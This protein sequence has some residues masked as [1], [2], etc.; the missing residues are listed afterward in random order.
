[1]SAEP[2]VSIGT[3]GLTDVLLSSRYRL[4]DAAGSGPAGHVYAA[5]DVL[6][7]RAV[8]VKVLDAV[9]EEVGVGRAVRAA[10]AAARA[11]GARLVEVLDVEYGRPT[12]VVLGLV[13]AR[14]LPVAAP[15]GLGV[16]PA[17]TVAED[18]LSALAAL[19]AAGAVHRDV[20]AENVLLGE[21]GRAWLT[22]AGL[23]EAAR[24]VG[25]GLRVGADPLRRR[26]PAP[27]PEQDLGVPATARSDVAAAGALLG[28][29]LAGRGGPEVERVLRRATSPDPDARHRDAT[30]LLTA[31][32]AA[33]AAPRPR[34]ITRP[35]ALPAPPA[36]AAPPGPPAPPVTG[37]P[38]TPS[39]LVRAS[40]GPVAPAHAAATT[41]A[42]AVDEV[43][44]GRAE[45]EGY[46]VTV[47]VE[48]HVPRL[49]GRLTLAA[50]AITAAWLLVGAPIANLGAEEPPP[51]VPAVSGGLLPTPAGPA[52][53]GPDGLVAPAALPPQEL[54]AVLAVATT[55]QEDLGPRTEDLLS[56][57]Q[58][59]DRL[60]GITREAEAAELY[61][62]AAVD[63]VSASNSAQVS[64]EVADLLRP[65]VTL[66]GLAALVDLDPAAAGAL[67]RTF[68]ARVRVLATLEGEPRREEAFALWL[69]SQQGVADATLTPAFDAAARAVLEDIVGQT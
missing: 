2:A 57:L 8:V 54:S 30:D 36:P 29:L 6:L 5:H 63:A 61:G 9:E 25:L 34:S 69:L 35:Q 4:G 12:F 38:P 19:H 50:A 41:D 53:G 62:I 60:R 37:A 45:P 67:G 66:D 18:V 16:H 14:L 10:R 32:R 56:R 23:S 58:R 51:A 24:D 52:A 15:E 33:L 55:A 21:D 40:V 26:A 59:L 7:D 3:A 64:A 13:A 27:S 65:E 22:S 49:A 31:L 68:A 43:A 44:A 17:V 48:P 42:V 39:A 11:R 47:P 20:R 28:V 46:L 1:M